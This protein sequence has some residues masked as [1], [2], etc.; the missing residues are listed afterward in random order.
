MCPF[1]T[2]QY[3]YARDVYTD[4]TVAHFNMG[5]YRSV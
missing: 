1:Y 5:D 2:C 3:I 4:K